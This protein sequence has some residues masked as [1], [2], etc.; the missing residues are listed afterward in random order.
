MKVQELIEILSEV[1]GDMDIFFP[2]DTDNFF[3]TCAGESCIL[4]G[5]A[6]EPP[7]YVLAP[8]GFFD[9]DNVNPI[10]N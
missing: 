8:H 2:M 5:E 1:D 3:R 9:N 4:E 6:G 7:I 10:L